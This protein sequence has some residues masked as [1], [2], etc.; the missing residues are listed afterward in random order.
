MTR[1]L[2]AIEVIYSQNN[3]ILKILILKIFI[4]KILI[5][6]KFFY[7]NT[8]NNICLKVIL[9]LRIKYFITWIL[10]SK[11]ELTNN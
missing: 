4:L 10:V 9:L 6:K 11:I 1:L 7:A 3:I 2:Q 5:L 8:L